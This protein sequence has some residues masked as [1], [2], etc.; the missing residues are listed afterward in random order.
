MTVCTHT[1]RAAGRG[2]GRVP[3]RSKRS[4]SVWRKLAILRNWSVETEQWPWS[5]ARDWDWCTVQI[6][7]ARK[8]YIVDYVVSMAGS[9]KGL[10]IN[11]QITTKPARHDCTAV[12]LRLCPNRPPRRSPPTGDW[13]CRWFLHWLN[14][15]VGEGFCHTGLR[16][17]DKTTSVSVS[18]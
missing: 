5:V 1:R 9:R 3:E 17:I 10:I 11:H 13:Q 6:Q 4:V 2:V 14:R 16:S 8:H 12:T 15:Q 7:K 18:K